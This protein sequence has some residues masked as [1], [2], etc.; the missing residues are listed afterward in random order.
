MQPGP[1]QPPKKV[2]S[3]RLA[4]ILSLVALVVVASFVGLIFVF[5][6]SSHGTTN[7]V[8]P[9]TLPTATPSP[10]PVILSVTGTWVGTDTGGYVNTWTLTQTG[11]SI[12]GTGIDH[13]ASFSDTEKITGTITGN[14]VSLSVYINETHC[15]QNHTL[16]LSSDGKSLG[17][18]FIGCN[19]NNYTIQLTKQ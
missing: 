12:T 7:Q 15:Y 5:A 16:T 11:T 6:N 9:T 3:T 18:P 8:T 17:G 2:E 1:I 4:V 14:S 19:G 10:T 13:N